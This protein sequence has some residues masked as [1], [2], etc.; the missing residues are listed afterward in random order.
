MDGKGERRGPDGGAGMYSRVV[1]GVDDTP[2][3]L[4]A[5]RSAV[6]MARTGQS[7]LVAVRSW[8]LGLPKHGGR[9]LRHLGR[10]GT[11]LFYNGVQQR[12]ESDNLVR[13]A[14]QTA[15]GGIP[16]NVAVT[17]ATP[18]GDPGLVLTRIADEGGDVLVVGTEPRH[19]ARRLVHGSV[20]DYCVRHAQCPV[21]VVPAPD[22]A[23]ERP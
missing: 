19:T 16:D 18:E 12:I 20:S 2:G 4:A 1:V 7:R 21:I 10:H 9:R 5:L 6:S 13:D 11:V 3:G 22:Q 8:E 23:G 17:I 15:T 14:F